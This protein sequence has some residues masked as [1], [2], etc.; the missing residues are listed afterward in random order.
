[1]NR[2]SRSMA[3]T[4]LSVISVSSYAKT[5]KYELTNIHSGNGEVTYPNLEFSQAQSAV[6]TI[7]KDPLNTDLQ[8]SSV[9]I[10]FPNAAKLLATGFKKVNHDT[11]RAVVNNAWIYRQVFVDIRGVDFNSP[12]EGAPIIEAFISEKFAFNQPEIDPTGA[13]LF[14]LH[15]EGLRD[16][17]L[18]KVADMASVTLDG[19]RL[20]LSLKSNLSF[21]PSGEP[22]S[23]HNKGFVVE[24]LW[25]GKG[26][27]TMYIPAPFPAEDYDGIEAIGININEHAAPNGSEYTVVI[28]F[29]DQNGH[30]IFTPEFPLPHLIGEVYGQQ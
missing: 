30:E 28:K 7:N 21:A 19:K 14:H 18:S 10:A 4:L 29:R 22:M 11:Y 15:G 20:T 16:I 27:K 6:F 1:M 3:V 26:Q 24:A 13:H 12:Q 9:E 23:G 8:I 25:M 17:T 2:F 5:F